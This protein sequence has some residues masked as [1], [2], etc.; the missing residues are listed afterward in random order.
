[1]SVARYLA[2]LALL[3]VWVLPLVVAAVVVRRRL[4]P[5]AHA[6]LAALAVAVLSLALVITTVQLL[7]AVGLFGRVGLSVACPVVAGVVLYGAHRIAP[8]PREPM[9][10]PAF[11]R[12]EAVVAVIVVAATAAVYVAAT[13]SSVGTGIY[14]VD[15]LSYHLPYAATFVQSGWTTRLHLGAPGAGVSFHPADSELVQAMAMLAFGRDVL[16]PLLNLGWLAL[17]LLAGWCVGRRRGRSLLSLTSTAVV[18]VVPVMSRNQG[19][20]AMSDTASLALLAACVAFAVHAAE[21]V[22]PAPVVAVAV[23]GV[24][25]GLAVAT[26]ETVLV[27]IAAASV[28]LAFVAPAGLRRRLLMSWLVPLVLLG[29]YWYLRNVVRVGTPLPT[30][31]LGPLPHS[32]QFAI[33]RYGYS[34][35]RYLT[36]VDVI[37]HWFHPGLRLG[38]GPAWWLLLAAAL[39]SA[40]MTL[41]PRTPSGIRALAAVASVGAVGYVFT[42]TTALGL[43][44]KPYLFTANLRYLLPALMLALLAGSLAAGG[45]VHVLLCTALVATVALTVAWQGTAPALLR[46]ERVPAAVGFVVVGAMLVVVSAARGRALR[47][48]AST[49]LAVVAVVSMLLLAQHYER[50]RYRQPRTPQAALFAWASSAHHQRIGLTGYVDEYPLVGNDLSNRVQYVGRRLPHATL[51]D[52]TDCRDYLDA[53][54]SGRYDFV[55]VA[56]PDGATATPAAEAWLMNAVTG[57]D[58]VLRH[59]AEVVFRIRHRLDPAR[60]RP[61]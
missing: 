2:G 16:A 49:A 12:W 47:I 41:R 51:V 25:A 44:N 19:G 54:N 13:A 17:A 53:V 55:T 36:N 18:F 10:V 42:P 7:G 38:F 1:M 33:D 57:N 6:A 35:S 61:R 4:L 48:G 59:G 37:R 21:A 5:T 50:D 27:V 52:I 39:A 3:A 29:S 31:K 32:R 23:A 28:A 20:S 60:C 56:P 34:V 26:K 22:T 58:I 9:S 40:V 30:T 43:V 8:R 15:S 11:R 46:N 45:R 24:A 14:Q